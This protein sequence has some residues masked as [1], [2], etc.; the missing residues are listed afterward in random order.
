ML[1]SSKPRFKQTSI[2]PH[3]RKAHASMLKNKLD[4]DHVELFTVKRIPYNVLDSKQWKK[5]MNDAAPG[6]TPPSATTML[7]SM[8]PAEAKKVYLENIKNLRTKSHLTLTFDGLT[9]RN[10]DSIYTIHVITPERDVFLVKGV[11]LSGE[12]H[13]AERIAQVVIEVCALCS[14]FCLGH[15]NNHT[16]TGY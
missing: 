12:S 3:A 5:L 6:Y 10:P 7:D 4:L 9:T 2:A 1:S 16:Y 8:L 14:F 13:T 15:L 11:E